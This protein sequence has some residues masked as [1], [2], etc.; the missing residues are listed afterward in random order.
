MMSNPTIAG[1]PRIEPIVPSVRL[2]AF[3][4]PQWLFEPKSDGFRGVLYLTHRGCAFY[5]KRGNTMSRFRDLAEQV[6]AKLPAVKSS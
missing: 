6:H 5:S 4:D 2:S 1:L 3:N